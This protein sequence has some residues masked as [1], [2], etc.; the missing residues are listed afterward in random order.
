MFARGRGE[1]TLGSPLDALGSLTTTNWQRSSRYI[2]SGY[3]SLCLEAALGTSTTMGD[4]TNINSSALKIYLRR[5]NAQTDGR[6]SIRKHSGS[7]RPHH[8]T[9]HSCY[10]IKHHSRQDL[11]IFISPGSSAGVI[12]H[13]QLTPP[14]IRRIAEAEC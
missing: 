13:C 11:A 3:L 6:A 12:C 8:H 2:K 1:M 7:E 4:P 10:Y 9:A 14:V 5:Q